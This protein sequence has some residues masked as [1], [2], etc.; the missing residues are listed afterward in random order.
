LKEVNVKKRLLIVLAIVLTLTLLLTFVTSA[1]YGSVWI[2]RKN[3]LEMYYYDNDQSNCCAPKSGVSIGRYYR[4]IID[5][6]EDGTIS[7]DFEWGSDGTSLGVEP[8]PGDVDW[9]L[10][11][12]GGWWSNSAA[13][14]D[15]AQKHTGTRSARLYRGNLGFA[16]KQAYYSQDPP[17]YRRFY[18]KKDIGSVLYTTNGDGD[19][20]IFVR[21]RTIEE[22]LPDVDMDKIEYYDDGEWKHVCYELNNEWHCIEF[23]NID[24]VHGTYDIWVDNYWVEGIGEDGTVNMLET[25]AYNGMTAYYNM[26]AR[27]SQCWIDDILD[28]RADYPDLPSNDYMFDDLHDC[29]HTFLGFT[30]MDNYG[31]GF[32]AMAE[33]YDYYNFSY[34]HDDEVTNDDEDSDG[35]PDDF[36]A[37]VDAIDNGWPVAF[38][39]WFP[40]GG[41]ISNDGADNWPPGWSHAIAI[42]GYRYWEN[43]YEPG[44][45][46]NFRIVCTDNCCDANELVLDWDYVVENGSDFYIVIITDN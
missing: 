33:L 34:V 18:F 43:L 40:D 17:T 36:K 25:S 29:M 12:M 24:W 37:I 30:N 19:N 4:E 38:A 8:P 45:Y 42:R 23:K 10:N 46:C 26:G 1:V 39:G 2:V 27:P 31:D 6:D 20:R 21:V 13:E 14:I 5:R 35:F 7:E 32:I 16:Y 3:K 28:R 22:Y 15:T 41:V 11:N 9:T 44:D